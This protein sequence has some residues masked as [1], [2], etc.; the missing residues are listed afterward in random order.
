MKIGLLGH[1]DI[2]SL[3]AL[4]RVIRALP[5]HDFAVFLSP[6]LRASGD[7]HPAMAELAAFDAELCQ[8]FY[9]GDVPDA[10]DP[11]RCRELP[12]PN[13]GAGLDQLRDHGADL[14][15]SIRYR[16]ILRDPAISVPRLGIINLHSGLL[17]D[18]RG[19]M[20]T[21]WAMLHGAGEVGTTLHRIVDSG[22]DTGPIIHIERLAVEP[23]E[24]YLGN[25]LRLYP[26]ACDNL[27][28]VARR[29]GSG[30]APASRPQPAGGA[31]YSTP[32]A[33]DVDA[34][35]ARGLRLFDGSESRFLTG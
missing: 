31:Y 21:F 4:Q 3:T 16:R 7:T 29:L 10:M 14:L 24:S 26:K 19:V 17:P 18:Y 34:F 13:Q 9:Q 20:A 5:E 2:C 8:R 15:V 1:P 12:E 28:G 27:A 35:L 23:A 6:P 32:V 25:V 11:D 22:I 33:A 30:K